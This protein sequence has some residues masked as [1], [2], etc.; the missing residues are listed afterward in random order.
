MDLYFLDGLA[1]STQRAYSVAKR[2]YSQFCLSNGMNPVPASE[3]QLCLFISSLANDKLAHSTIK[4]YLSGIRHLH[5]EQG[6]G[7]PCISN[8]ARL[9]QVLRGIKRVQAKSGGVK[10]QGFQSLSKYYRP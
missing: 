9:E 7:D 8:M 6:R 10:G 2:R 5:V 4:S 1:E 3:H